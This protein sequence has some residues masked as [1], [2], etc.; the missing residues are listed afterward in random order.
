[1]PWYTTTKQIP[2]FILA[3]PMVLLA[4]SLVARHLLSMRQWLLEVYGSSTDGREGKAHWPIPLHRAH[5]YVLHTAVLLAFGLTSMHVQVITRLIFAAA[6]AVYWQAAW[7]IAPVNSS[8]TGS[9]STVV[10]CQR[11]T[12]SSQA[13]WSYCWAYSLI[14]TIMFSSYYP[15]T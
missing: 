8:S 12:R 1:M 14:G 13:V 11:R 2:N 9:T 6:P 15:W 10:R 7:L 4:G 3:L 5:P